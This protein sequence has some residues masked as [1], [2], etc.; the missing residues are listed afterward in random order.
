M[1]QRLE[2]IGITSFAELAEANAAD[3]CDKVATVL[4]STCWKNAPRAR[5]RTFRPPLIAHG[6]RRNQS[7]NSPSGE[8]ITA[9][10]PRLCDAC[11]AGSM[12]QTSA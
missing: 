8:Y 11:R 6:G 7:H 5:K 4:G 1:V 9:I 10:L 2:E 12:Q 3:I